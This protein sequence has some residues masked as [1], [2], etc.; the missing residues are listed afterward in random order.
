MWDQSGL[1][2]VGTR[3]WAPRAKSGAELSQR[4]APKGA[5]GPCSTGVPPN[6]GR[7]A[8]PGP[9]PGSRGCTPT[10]APGLGRR[11]IFP[12]GHPSPITPSQLLCTRETGQERKI[13][14]EGRYRPRFLQQHV[15]HRPYRRGEPLLADFGAF[16]F[17][18]KPARHGAPVSQGSGQPLGFPKTHAELSPCP[19]V[20]SVLQSRAI[21]EPNNHCKN[22]LESPRG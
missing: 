12:P 22:H 10:K 17:S 8:G 6:T 14:A 15:A 9:A 16:S 20:S 1:Y 21:L 19:H 11:D 7:G 18:L 5:P 2:S 3:L 4:D 13:A